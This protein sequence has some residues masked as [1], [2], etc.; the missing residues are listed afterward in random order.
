M[1][2]ECEMWLRDLVSHLVWWPTFTF[3]EFFMF[4]LHLREY[5][6]LPELI[7]LYRWCWHCARCTLPESGRFFSVLPV[8]ALTGWNE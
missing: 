5:P 3:E 1:F 8:L 4:F 2:E 7:S 6:E